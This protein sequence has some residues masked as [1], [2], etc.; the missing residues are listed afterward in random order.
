MTMTRNKISVIILTK[1]SQRYI[2]KCL[3]ALER[4][5]EIIVLDNGSSDETIEII[6]SFPNIKLYKGTFIGFGPLKNL[7]ASYALNNWILSVDSDEI[8]TVELVDELLELDLDEKTIYSILRDNH[9]NHKL[10]NSCGWGDDWV[11]RFY[12]KKNVS[13]NLNLVH[14]SLNISS[15]IKVK[16]LNNKFL[17]YT[18][19]TPSELIQKMDKYSELWAQDHLGLKKSSP[20]IAILKALASFIKSYFIKK[21]F[22]QGYEGLLLSVNNANNVFYKYIKLYELIKRQ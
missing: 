19:S 18:Y 10:I 15:N 12:Y 6:N 21:G 17:H 2:A 14:E 13:F 7:A 5:D 16:K 3:S 1:N 8:F 11:N 9:Y 4:F 22:L 20:S